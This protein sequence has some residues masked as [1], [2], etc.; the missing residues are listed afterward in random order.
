M[1]KGQAETYVEAL[2]SQ[3]N[4]THSGYVDYYAPAV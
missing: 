1:Q 4:T 2:N 3:S